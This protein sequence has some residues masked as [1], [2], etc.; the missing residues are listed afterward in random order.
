MTDTVIQR[1]IEALEACVE[2]LEPIYLSHDC[3][4]DEYLCEACGASHPKNR[5]EINHDDDCA[6]IAARATLAELRGRDTP[7]RDE[8]EALNGVAFRDGDN[9]CPHKDQPSWIFVPDCPHDDP[10]AS[11]GDGEFRAQLTILREPKP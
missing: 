8:V 6:L 4:P 11:L 10:S 5:A 2:A 1:A 9:F 3:G 7:S